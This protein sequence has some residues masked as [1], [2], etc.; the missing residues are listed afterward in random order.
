[1]ISSLSR[2]WDLC[3]KTCI[4]T[5]K[6]WPIKDSVNMGCKKISY[7]TELPDRIVFD[8]KSWHLDAFLGISVGSTISVRTSIFF[9]RFEVRFWRTNSR[10]GNFEARFWVANT[11]TY[12]PVDVA[13]VRTSKL[14]VRCLVCSKVRRF[15]V[16]FRRKNTQGSESSKFGFFKFRPNTRYY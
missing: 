5:V 3:I 9:A 10:F 11:Q 1:M 4:S 14:R 16:W 6:K 13:K 7:F 2:S 8:K 15:D 12:F